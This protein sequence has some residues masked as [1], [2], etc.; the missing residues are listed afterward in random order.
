M[1]YKAIN[2]PAVRTTNFFSLSQ[3]VFV[4][5]GLACFSISL[6]LPTFFTSA[7]DIYGIWVLLTGWVGLIFLQ[8]AWFSNPLNLLAM[9]VSPNKPRIALLL[10]LLSLIL[11]SA[12]FG[13]YEIPTG[14]NNEIIFIKEFGLGFYLWIAAHIFIF[15]A[16]LMNY[17]RSINKSTEDK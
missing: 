17:I 8:L 16:L 9:L 13:F 5:I 6:F 11:A 10:S 15:L 7:E 2:Y 1:N 12:A 14:I 3:N 4:F